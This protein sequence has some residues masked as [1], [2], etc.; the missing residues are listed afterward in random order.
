MV[1]IS[2][3]RAL[4]SL[5]ARSPFS[6]FMPGD[7]HE[8]HLYCGWTIFVFGVTHSVAHLV[9][10]ANQGNL[11][12][13]FH[14]F[15]GVSGFLILVSLV[16]ICIPMMIYKERVKYEIR[17]SLHYFFLL[18]AFA[19]CFHTS[20]KSVPNGGFSAYVFGTIL[21]LYFLDS[22]YCI[23]FMSE[24]IETT[25]FD[26]LPTGVRVTMKVSDFFQKNGAQGGY[27]YVCIPWV[28]KFQ[29]H[30]FSLFE[31]P[32]EP[33]E[34]QIFLQRA[35]DWTNKVH[36]YLQRDTVR[37]AWIQGPFPSPYASAED[38]DN[39]ILVAS[40][41]GIT[42]ALSVIRAHKD[43]R[44]INLIWAVRDRHLLEFFLRHLYLDH[45]GWNLIFYT[46]KEPLR[47]EEVEI[48]TNTNLCILFGRPKLG[49]LIPNIIYGIELGVGLP[50]RYVPE[51]KKVAAETM[52]EMFDD[53]YS[54][55]T[56]Q[57]EAISEIAAK[58]GYEMKPLISTEESLENESKS[59]GRRSD[60]IM[61][62]LDLGF[63]PWEEHLKAH[64]YVKSLN[65][66]N[67]ISTW[68]MLYCGGAK[69]LET[70]LRKVS[71]RYKIDLHV[72]SFGW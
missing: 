65:R 67:V 11:Y 15:S 2:K 51:V 28:D 23:F 13:L 59:H 53:E 64:E 38:Y 55:D 50:E 14:H 32:S 20:P 25:K 31:N 68:G 17:K 41:I 9:R 40:G 45:N 16:L 66:E 26:V 37:P 48:F 3:L 39:Q 29:W 70:D 33:Q 10:W 58:Q 60:A 30:A 8:L 1:Y 43:S 49:E 52:A 61:T 46:G 24:K 56:K 22:I 71:D 12:L 27:C 35:G 42:P 5:L 47:E 4:T 72:E 63:K 19:L 6:I 36:R 34:R 54:I 21:V 69:V 18:F 57:L 44:R 62:H 7:L